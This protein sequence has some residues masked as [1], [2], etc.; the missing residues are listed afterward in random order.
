MSTIEKSIQ[1]MRGHSRVEV[2]EVIRVGQVLADSRLTGTLLQ[3]VFCACRKVLFVPES[4]R[5]T[6]P[7]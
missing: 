7:S 3:V 2:S 5:S 1:E 4:S 6:A